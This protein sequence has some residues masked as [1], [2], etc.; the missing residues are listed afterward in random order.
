MSQARRNPAASPLEAGRPVVQARPERRHKAGR[1]PLVVSWRKAPLAAAGVAREAATDAQPHGSLDPLRLR[2]L[3]RH[4]LD[5]GRRQRRAAATGAAELRHYLLGE[6]AHLLL[7]LPAAQARHL[8]VA[9]YQE[10]LGPD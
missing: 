9:Q 5:G 3:V 6:A 1:A 8:E 10:V 4:Q 2:R 7:D